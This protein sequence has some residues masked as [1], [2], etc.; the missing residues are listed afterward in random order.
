MATTTQKI[1]LDETDREI[2]TLIQQDGKYS[3]REISKQLGGVSVTK[4]KNHL[5]RLNELGVIKGV[6]TILDCCLL[7]YHEMLLFFVRVNNAKPIQEILDNLANISSVNAIY[8][9]SGNYPIFCMAKC[10]EKDDQILL[11]EQ[12]KAI[13]GVE[14]LITQVV[15]KR[16]KEDMRIKIP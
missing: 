11:L 5:D 3:L 13:E 16:V 9:V 10:V 6:F 8:Q 2:L 12:V 14:E 7:G 1:A 4:V 15:L